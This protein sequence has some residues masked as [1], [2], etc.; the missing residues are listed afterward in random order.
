MRRILIIGSKGQVGTALIRALEE[1]PDVELVV[2]SDIKDPSPDDHSHYIRLDATSAEE[3]RK[4]LVVHGINEVYLMAAMLS[5]T[6]ERNPMKAWDLNM[7]SL[8][9]VLELGREGLVDRIF[10]PSSIAVY[11]HHAQIIKTP[12]HETLQ[13]TTVYGIS[14]V[15][16]ELWC[17]YYHEKHGVDVRSV[18]YPGLIGSRSLPGG[19]TTDYAV[20]IFHAALEKG[21][22]S[23]FLSPDRRLPMMHMNDAIRA[24]ME[25]MAAPPENLSV[26]TSYNIQAMSFDPQTLAAEIQRHIPEFTIEYLPDHRDLIAAD[27]PDSIDDRQAREDWHWRPSVDLTSLV[28]LMLTDL[29]IKDLL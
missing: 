4:T 19:G 6:A 9:N 25:L 12:Q 22:F 29:K 11:G 13:P 17:N 23:C 1:S 28:D 20:H 7:T 16:G 27:W 14:K 3:I 21:H 18:R 24:T 2:S 8:F 26:R 10:W 5:A 15:S